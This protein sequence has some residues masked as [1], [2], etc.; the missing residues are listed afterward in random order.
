MADMVAAMMVVITVVMEAITAA[1][2]AAI[3]AVTWV[4]IRQYNSVSHRSNVYYFCKF[5]VPEILSL[6]AHTC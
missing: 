3:W 5:K 4:A 2:E 6:G 1:T